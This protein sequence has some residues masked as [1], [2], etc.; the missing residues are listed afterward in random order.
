[1]TTLIV[2][3][4]SEATD[5]AALYD[6]LL[7][8]DGNSVGEQSRVA[9]GLLPQQDNAT[10]VVALVPADRLSWHRVQLPKGC[11]GRRFFQEG[12]PTRLR[13]VL[14]GLLEDQL[15]DET[16]HLHFALEPGASDAVPVW[17]A[18][19]DRAWLQA[20]LQALA[21]AGRTV[22]R[23]VPEFAPDALADALYVT[24]EQD[25]PRIV[26]GNSGGGVA[27]WPLSKASVALLNLPETRAIVAEPAL[28]ALAEEC[29]RRG[30]TLQQV[31][32]RRL[33]AIHS[34]WNLAQFDLVNS[35]GARTRKRLSA[36]VVSLLRAPR[37]RAA[38][39]AMLALLL[40]NLAG[41]NAWAW[42][43]QAQTEA[44]RGAI[45]QLLTSTFPN[46]RVVV[47]A[48]V[49][50]SKEV[51]ALQQT[52]GAASGRDMEVMMAVFAGV[53]APGT[54]PTAL[55]YSVGELRLK[56]IRLKPDEIAAIAFKLK[57]QAYQVSAE[58][59]SMVIR[60]G[61]TP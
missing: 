61:A 43:E 60:A 7:S 31:G 57:P 27:V 32:Q 23:V 9:L 14:E 15:L 4:S 48:P 35:S 13:A 53:A 16:A 12:G 20:S 54:V 1:M 10:E 17:V 30:A 21:Q 51:A 47:D 34:A 25:H 45:R 33:Q 37:W 52:S 28:A 59:D 58:A 26:F 24:G 38:R 49:Q 40:V 41:L 18:V 19:C 50:M 36:S 44:R 42:R 29:F 2:T 6:Y 11:L 22:N 56:G 46:V 8:P 55:E 3:L 5:A 39:F